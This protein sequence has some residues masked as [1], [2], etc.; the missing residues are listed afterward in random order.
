M[1]SEL[2]GRTNLVYEGYAGQERRLALGLEGIEIHPKHA[3]V[4]G[5]ALYLD[6][7]MLLV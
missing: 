1:K 6:M 3:V 4:P 5:F 2:D 7:L